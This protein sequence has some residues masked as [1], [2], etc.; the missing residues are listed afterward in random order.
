[1]QAGPPGSQAPRWQGKTV[2][3]RDRSAPLREFLR[4]ESGSALILVA[5]IVAAIIWANAATSSYD[6]FWQAKLSIRVS[7]F[8]ISRTC[9]PGSTAG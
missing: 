3:A 9:G 1:M 6:T 2:W 5:G 7:S 8:G 4:T